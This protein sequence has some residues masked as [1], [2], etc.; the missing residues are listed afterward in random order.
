M[1]IATESSDSSRRSMSRHVSVDAQAYIL[2]NFTHPYSAKGNRFLCHLAGLLK[3]INPE[4]IDTEIAWCYGL[5]RGDLKCIQYDDVTGTLNAYLNEHYGDIKR[6]L[7]MNIASWIITAV[8]MFDRSQFKSD[9]DYNTDNS[10]DR[11]YNQIGLGYTVK[12]PKATRV[13]LDELVCAANAKSFE[14]ECEL[15]KLEYHLDMAVVS[16]KDAYRSAGKLFAD[17]VEV[18]DCHIHAPITGGT[19]LVVDYADPLL[20]LINID[21]LNCSEDGSINAMIN[22]LSLRKLRIYAK[23]IQLLSGLRH[24]HLEKDHC[25]VR[26]PWMYNSDDIDPWHKHSTSVPEEKWIDHLPS[27]RPEFVITL[28]T[29]QQ[30]TYKGEHINPKYDTCP[31]LAYLRSLCDFTQRS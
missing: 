5:S 6:D 7:Y 26:D 21:E 9:N 11:Y 24:V 19:K 13:T 18:D 12:L 15:T 23:I 3:V 31:S 22:A 25:K 28:K 14:R 4:V 2:N 29:R 20:S 17:T 27:Y 16:V 1:S 30:F 10:A 8:T